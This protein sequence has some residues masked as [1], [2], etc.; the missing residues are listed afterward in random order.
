MRNYF[1]KR[2]AFNF[3]LSFTLKC[4]KQRESRCDWL[5]LLVEI[6]HYFSS[7]QE[8]SGVM[9]RA[10]RHVASFTDKSTSRQELHASPHSYIVLIIYIQIWNILSIYGYV[11]DHEVL[12]LFTDLVEN[13]ES[14]LLNELMCRK[15]AR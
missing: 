11:G 8:V 1:F 14:Y 13:S 10:W 7:R 6:H 12:T 15:V 9:S 4:A 3:L 2:K 5:L